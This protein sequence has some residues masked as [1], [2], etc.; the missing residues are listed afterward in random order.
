MITQIET[1]GEI[2]EMQRRVKAM[3]RDENNLP[4]NLGAPLRKIE[5]SLK[6]AEIRA[7]EARVH[8]ARRQ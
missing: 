6:D 2:W 5:D 3:L 1:L 4:D 7:Q 8:I